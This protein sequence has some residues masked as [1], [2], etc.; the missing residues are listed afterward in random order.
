M[1][2]LAIVRGGTAPHP[3]DLNRG[4]SCDRRAHRSALTA[5]VERR[6]SRLYALQFGK[7]VP[8]GLVGRAPASLV[9]DHQQ[10]LH[11]RVR[12]GPG[13]DLRRRV[14]PRREQE[15]ETRH[16]A[17]RHPEG[18]DG[19]VEQRQGIHGTAELRQGEVQLFRR[20]EHHGPAD[21]LLSGC[22]MRLSHP[23]GYDIG[24]GRGTR[25]DVRVARTGSAVTVDTTRHTKARRS[26]RGKR[27]PRWRVL[28][29]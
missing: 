16:R 17:L 9:H 26:P 18:G 24:R 7:G 29:K 25:V 21:G 22:A 10:D 13:G 27:M 20:G 14:L 19:R 11:V 5:S 28:C 6:P 23:G 2:G 8:D 15:R 4:C 3:V 12:P 1:K